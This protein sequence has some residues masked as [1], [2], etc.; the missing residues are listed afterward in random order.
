[1]DDTIAFEFAIYYLPDPSSEPL[2]RLDEIL[3][4]S[5]PTFRK[6]DR[7][8]PEVREPIVSARMLNDAQKTYAP[9]NLQSL[10]YFGRGV[11]KED[12]EALQRTNSVLVLS[13]AYSKDFVWT[14][15]R[16]ALA[17]S[18]TL[19][20]ETQGLL[21]D[22]ETR[23]VF[24]PDAWEKKRLADWDEEVPEVFSHVVMH[25][26][27][28]G[29][30]VRAITLGMAKFGLPDIAIEDFPWSLNNQL[31]Q[32]A[33]LC[34]QALA[35]GQRCMQP[36][37]F[38]LKINEIKNRTLRES[39]LASLKPNAEKVALLSLQ[40][41]TCEEG[42]PDNRIIE[43]RFDRYP[44]ADQQSRQQA[45]V[46]SLF[47]YEDR[48]VAVKQNASLEAESKR[49][50]ANLA[51][52]RSV[53]EAGLAPG[54]FIQVK[55]PFATPDNGQEWMWV[56]ITLWRGDQIKG[57]LKNEP[58]SI[59]DLHG[60]QTVEVSQRDVFDYI[61]VHADGTQEGNS[62]APLLDAQGADE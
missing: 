21:W 13:F 58:F 54:E 36:G 52:L 24:S 55:A 34:G 26:Y 19:A 18:L 15:M 44:G 9:P 30:Y 35:E 51:K 6:V 32:V 45:L 22:E 4:A 57:L 12:A 33:N 39:S 46:A 38:D 47:G 60:G 11:S 62:T 23:E 43:I 3:A 2:T 5:N 37:K 40:L 7:L 48:V 41:G 25:A 17:L 16:S 49:A 31:G 8:L 27:N 59:P 42:D 10:Q 14:G 29:E 61:Y 20:R 28:H 53:F 56:E 50:R 1:M